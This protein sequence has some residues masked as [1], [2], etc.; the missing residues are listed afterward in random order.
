MADGRAG[1]LKPGPVIR[2]GRADRAREDRVDGGLVARRRSGPRDGV[3][4]RH[5]R[6]RLR[7]LGEIDLEIGVLGDADEPLEPALVVD[8]AGDADGLMRRA[9]MRVAADPRRDLAAQAADLVE[10]RALGRF[11]QPPPDMELVAPLGRA[12][13]ALD[14]ECRP[15]EMMAQMRELGGNVAGVEIHDHGLHLHDIGGARLALFA[16]GAGDD[17]DGG[18]LPPGPARKGGHPLRRG[19]VRR[20][21]DV[22]RPSVEAL[23]LVDKPTNGDQPVAVAE[24]DV[25]ERRDLR[26]VRLDPE[27][28]RRGRGVVEVA[29]RVEM[30]DRLVGHAGWL[31]QRSAHGQNRHSWK[32][33][34]RAM[35]GSSSPASVA[36]RIRT[37]RSD[38]RCARSTS[39]GTSS[40]CSSAVSLLIA[41]KSAG[42]TE[43]PGT[44]ASMYA[45]YSA[46]W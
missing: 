7:E 41:V 6:H 16:H 15:A 23:P 9:K 20:D 27:R 8:A 43:M 46:I 14:D 26:G 40:W 29:P 36:R 3:H 35:R 13:A 42:A 31:Q 34:V 18:A 22:V 21:P 32:S 38:M 25:E 24:D 39:K 17:V 5:G 4:G 30:D 2:A 19:A 37:P 33:R 1:P 45:W 12:P 44:V 11:G 10:I 28:V